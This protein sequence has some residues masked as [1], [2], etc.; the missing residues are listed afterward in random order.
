MYRVNIEMWE[1]SRLGRLQ[2]NPLNPFPP[3]LPLFV[4]AQRLIRLATGDAGVMSEEMDRLRDVFG[5]SARVRHF[6]NVPN[7]AFTIKY[8][9]AFSRASIHASLNAYP[10]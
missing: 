3:S 8:L 9:I 7:S 4:V 1:A 2:S 10:S 6:S 5:K